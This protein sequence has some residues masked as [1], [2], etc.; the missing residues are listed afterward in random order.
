MV[1]LNVY[2]MCSPLYNYVQCSLYAHRGVNLGEG[3]VMDEGDDESGNGFAF[4]LKLYC[5]PCLPNKS[6]QLYGV[7]RRFP[8]YSNNI[9]AIMYA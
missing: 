2:K 7:M 9:Y 6:D 3:L 8:Q 1:Y 5:L 4:M